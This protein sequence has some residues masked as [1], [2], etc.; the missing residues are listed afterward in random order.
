MPGGRPSD[1]TTWKAKAICMRLAQ[2]E[3]LR[4][5]CK[6]DLY[7]SRHAVFT[8]LT[9]RPEFQDQY[10]R[11]RELQAEHFLDETVEIAD[12]GRNDYIEQI[13]KNTGESYDRFNSEHVQRSKLRIDTRHWM[14]ERMAPKKFGSKQ[15]VDHT[16]SDSS[17]TPK[18][19]TII[20]EGDVKG[21]IDKI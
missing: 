21:I 13:N 20:T 10:A 3:S 11:A 7:P 18:G 8:W 4:S 1:Y 17:M 2:G 15:S 14:M 12:D 19:T 6:R 9:Q 5:I 16:S